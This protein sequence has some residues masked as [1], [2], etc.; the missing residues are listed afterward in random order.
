MAAIYRENTVPLFCLTDKIGICKLQDMK[1]SRFT[2][3]KP[4]VGLIAAI[5]YDGRY[6]AVSDNDARNEISVIDLVKKSTCVW[7][8]YLV[9][10]T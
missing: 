10:Y 4:A 8:M 2:I 6:L 5:S 9:V 3:E 1:L 7:N